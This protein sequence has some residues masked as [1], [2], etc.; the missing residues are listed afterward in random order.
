MADQIF[1]GFYQALEAGLLEGSPDIRVGLAMAGFTADADSVNVSDATDL[2]EFDGVGYSRLDAAN[3]VA[4][5]VDADDEWQ[6]DFDDDD[7]GDPVAAGSGAIEGLFVIL[8]VDGDPDNDYLLGY[9]DSGGFSVNANNG[10]LG[11]IV[12]EDGLLFVR[13]AT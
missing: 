5:Y 11:L 3:V 4:G 12:P 1:K 7:F 6:L 13:Q 8:N 10:P 9:T 2:D